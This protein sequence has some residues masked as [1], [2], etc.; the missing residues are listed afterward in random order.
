VVS[1]RLLIIED[2]KKTAAHLKK[3]LSENGFTVDVAHDG[4]EGSQLACAGAYALIVLDVMLP[5][6]DGW[7]ILGQLRGAGVM[8][9]VLFL[10]ARDRVEDRVK[11]L[12]MGA[13]DYLVKP[14]AFSEL[15]ARVRTILRRGSTAQPEVLRI[16]DLEID[17]RRHK[18]TRAGRGL[19]LTRRE[20]VLLS[21]LARSAGEVV[22]RTRIVEEVWDINFDTGTNIVE[23]TMRRLRAK[24]DDPF[25]MPLIHNVRGIG[26][27]L[28]TR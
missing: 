7:A 10:T 18:A 3:G 1:M 4:S 15:L 5:Q 8:T 17:T 13:D 23:A 12:E 11:G 22:S 24:V 19:Y 26:Y 2:E 25:E 21:C 16:A 20:F 9:P 14:Y 6:R 27:V 28:E